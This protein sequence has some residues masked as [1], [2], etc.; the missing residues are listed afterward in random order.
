M[1]GSA[2]KGMGVRA[3]GAGDPTRLAQERLQSMMPKFRRSG[4]SDQSWSGG[5]DLARFL[6]L[7]QEY[8]AAEPSDPVNCKK[9]RRRLPLCGCRRKI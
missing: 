4:L 5:P 8:C 3:A 7:D 6:G 9:Q 1:K 2:V